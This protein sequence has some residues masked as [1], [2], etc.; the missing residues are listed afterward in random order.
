MPRRVYVGPCMEV[1]TRLDGVEMVLTRG[2]AVDVSED[3]AAAL[4]RDEV[5]WATPKGS[6]PKSRKEGDS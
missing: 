2:D 3:Q 6:S 4:D 5:N 1:V